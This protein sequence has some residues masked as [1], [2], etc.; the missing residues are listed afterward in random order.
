MDKFG[1]ARGSPT[2]ISFTL[3]PKYLG[4]NKYWYP[5]DMGMNG[6]KSIAKVTVGKIELCRKASMAC[7]QISPKEL[8]LKR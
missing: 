2:M 4:G 5:V 6:L 7:F 3:R 8:L 1:T